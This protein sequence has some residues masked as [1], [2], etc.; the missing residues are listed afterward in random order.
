MF[1][2]TVGLAYGSLKLQN[3]LTNVSESH[4]SAGWAGGVGVEIALTGNWT[5]Q[6]RIP[7]RRSRRQFLRVSTASPWNS[8]QLLRVG[9]NYRF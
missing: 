6:S 5:R 3:T 4:T 7:L 1:Y 9:V 8:V 2:G